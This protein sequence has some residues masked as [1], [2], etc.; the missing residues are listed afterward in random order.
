MP[1]GVYDEMVYGGDTSLFHD[2]RQGSTWDGNRFK[3]ESGKAFLEVE[4]F[5]VFVG[6]GG[7][8]VQERGVGVKVVVLARCGHVDGAIIVADRDVQELY[9][10][11]A[12]ATL[13]V[14]F[15]DVI[16]EGDGLY[17]DDVLV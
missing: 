10:V 17:E 7:H 1:L 15:Q 3:L 2:G 16:E 14:V 12:D 8:L 13:I 5:D 11:V 6:R 4:L 9:F